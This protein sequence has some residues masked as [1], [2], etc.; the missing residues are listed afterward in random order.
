MFAPRLPR[1]AK[2]GEG[3]AT[4]IESRRSCCGPVEQATAAHQLN[5]MARALINR[6]I[7][8]AASSET[9]R[10]FLRSLI[11]RK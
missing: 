7:F 5:T 8:G 3:R 4:Q 1:S 2:V 11:T 10:Q 9:T 6:G